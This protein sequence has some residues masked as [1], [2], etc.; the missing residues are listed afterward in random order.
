MYYLPA[1]M[2]NIV[3]HNDLAEG[4]CL[5]SV[6]HFLEDIDV[7]LFSE[8]QRLVVLCFLQYCKSVIYKELHFDSQELD[9][10]FSCFSELTRKT[11]PL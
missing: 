2:I 8:E 6:I 5:D 4:V 7:K 10:V 1:Y 3:N 9:L 11:K